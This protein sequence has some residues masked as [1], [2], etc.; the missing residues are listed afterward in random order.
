MEREEAVE[1]GNILLHKD[2]DY[3]RQTETDR[4]TD[5]QTD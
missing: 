3:V 2:K 1:R 4:D 5:R